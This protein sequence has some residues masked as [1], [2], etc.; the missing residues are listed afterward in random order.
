MSLSQAS[1]ELINDPEI[2]GAVADKDEDAHSQSTGDRKFSDTGFSSVDAC[3]DKCRTQASG[4]VLMAV[5]SERRK[6]GAYIHLMAENDDNILEWMWS[7]KDG[8]R[9]FARTKYMQERMTP[10]Y[11]VSVERK[12]VV[13][14]ISR[15][16]HEL[17]IDCGSTTQ[18][19][20]VPRVE[21]HVPGIRETRCF[22]PGDVAHYKVIAQ[23]T[24]AV[25]MRM[26]L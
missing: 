17:G 3:H 24:R 10:R 14:R 13:E 12:R 6:K 21:L 26:A 5:V 18:W 22:V 1:G 20:L 8:M 19:V 7:S 15:H 9:P 4:Y 2:L 25:E 16:S 11:R 23:E